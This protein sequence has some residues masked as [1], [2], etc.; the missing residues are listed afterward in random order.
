[1]RFHLLLSPRGCRIG[2][3][4]HR[5]CTADV[6]L[7]LS[8]G[9]RR[10]MVRAIPPHLQVPP[11]G[12]RTPVEVAAPWPFT[13]ALHDLGARRRALILEDLRPVRTHY[14][15]SDARDPPD[16]GADFPDAFRSLRPSRKAG[17]PLLGL[18][19]DRP[20]IVLES[21]SPTPGRAELTFPPALPR[22]STERASFGMRTPIPIQRAVL[23]VSHHLDGF[24]P[25]PRDPIAGRCRS[26]GSPRFL[27]SRNR[28]PRDAL[29]ALR[30]LPSADSY[31][32]RDESQ[33][34]V[35]ARHRSG[36]FQPSCS[37]RTLPSRPFSLLVPT[38]LPPQLPANGPRIRP[39][40]EPGPQGLA[41]SSGP[42]RM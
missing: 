16:L 3:A 41:P 36:C 14:F 1:L 34:S 32:R 33:P 28:I 38:R 4:W 42:L 25:R 18:S 20:S 19:K 7:P 10:G 2:C 17:F 11:A 15:H 29:A 30:S 12:G 27:L 22:V 9:L 37:P 8:R 24:P 13:A 23:V 26:W 40:G 31:G 39:S 6:A 5:S 35:G 21:K